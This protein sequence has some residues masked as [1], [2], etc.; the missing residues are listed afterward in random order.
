MI[1]KCVDSQLID[2]ENIEVIMGD[3]YSCKY[4]V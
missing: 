1:K 3:D 2:D 4:F